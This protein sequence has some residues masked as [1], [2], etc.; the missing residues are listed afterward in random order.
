MNAAPPALASTGTAFLETDIF[1]TQ[2][3]NVSM[4]PHEGTF[5]MGGLVY[6]RGIVNN[7]ALEGSRFDGTATYRITGLGYTRLHGE[8]GRVSGSGS[9]TLSI[10]GDGALLGG[11]EIR[12]GDYPVWVDVAI[13]AGV[14]NVDIRLQ[15]GTEGMFAFADA[16]FEAGGQAMPPTHPPAFS[17]ALYLENDIGSTQRLNLSAHPTDG[18]FVMGGYIYFR[19]IANNNAVAG[20]GFDG[21]A[22]YRISGR[23][24][25]YTRLTGMFGRVSGTGSATLS[26]TGDGRLLGGYEHGPGDMPRQISVAIPS[27]VRDVTIRLQN[28]TGGL[29]ALGDAFFSASGATPPHTHPPAVGDAVYLENDIISAQRANIDRFPASGSFSLSEV[30]YFRGIMNNSLTAGNAYDGT[31]TYRVDGRG[32]TRLSGMFG[33]VSGTGNGTLVINAD[34]NLLGSFTLSPGDSPRQVDVSIP[35]GAQH[36]I[37]TLQNGSAGLFAFADAYFSGT[38]PPTT[39]QSF[40]ISPFASPV[41]G[42]YAIGG[43]TYRSGTSITLSVTP[44]SGW[45][46]DGWFEN[47]ARVSPDAV[48]T[49]TVTADRT[50]EAR[51]TQ[52]TIGNPHSGWATESLERARRMGLIPD[53]LSHYSVDYRLSITRLEFAGVAVRTYEALTG[54]TVLP[55]PGGT[56]SDTWDIDALKAHSAGIM[57]GTYNEFAPFDILT[58]E[59]AA[60]ALTRVYKRAT[61]PG[62][63]FANDANFPL[64]FT[65]PPRFAD[66]EHINSWTREGVYFMA[67]HG[68]VSGI[69]DNLFAPRPTTAAHEATNY[70]RAAREH[71]II[72]ALNLI[73]TLGN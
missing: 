43:G 2:R 13:P 54:I 68:I 49:F 3:A 73:E 56:F 7:N 22:T 12:P 25:E 19:G 48:W 8:F 30:T 9:A 42:G 33:R 46:F 17:D 72:M 28:G 45:E 23:G 51:F 16:C 31:A 27:G 44:N 35:P 40:T 53:S 50:L 52:R 24:Y 61:M 21:T 15:N 55:S 34:N 47:G 6:E 67:A 60:M 1:S 69:G 57:V 65:S 11:Y 70:G 26:I 64:Q 39:V 36:V 58:R 4:Y 29:F 10:T 41:Q 20:S 14:Q 63:T 18:S 37:I 32:F 62:W 71:A 59:M 5:S 38:A 66:D